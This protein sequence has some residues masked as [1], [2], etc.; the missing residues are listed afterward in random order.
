MKSY[1][2]RTYQGFCW[3]FNFFSKRNFEKIRQKIFPLEFLRDNGLR[4]PL[5]LSI[6]LIGQFSLHLME[7]LI[8]KPIETAL[9][10]IIL[11]SVQL[12][13]K[14][15]KN[16]SFFL[17]RN[18]RFCGRQTGIN[19]TDDQDIGRTID[20]SGTVTWQNYILLWVVKLI[21]LYII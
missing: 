19:K 12:C 14:R 21:S 8:G 2:P 20:H 10:D 13:K 7:R 17:P 1:Q 18:N 4:N 6:N 16:I 5:F 11:G 9:K 15:I 3:F